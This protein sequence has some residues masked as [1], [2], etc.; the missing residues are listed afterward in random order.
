MRLSAYWV[1]FP[2]VVQLWVR[3][4]SRFGGND[5]Q[6]SRP[7]QKSSRV[8]PS[9]SARPFAVSRLMMRGFRADPSAA[10]R[11]IR[12][13]RTVRRPCTRSPPTGIPAPSG[14]SEAIRRRTCAYAP[15]KGERLVET[16]PSGAN[17]WRRRSI[18]VPH[19]FAA[20][21]AELTPP[22]ASDAISSTRAR[23]SA[24]PRP[25]NG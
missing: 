3:G 6:P 5:N 4:F 20:P 14:R 22:M 25:V 7:S 23:N 2:V 12:A 9:A 13:S 17:T 11:V 18:R 1:P 24:S 8:T 21:M 15:R 19:S 10:S 16:I